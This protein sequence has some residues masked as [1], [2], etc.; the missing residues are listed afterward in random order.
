M[1]SLQKS[2]KTVRSSTTDSLSTTDHH[3]F[4]SFLTS[5]PMKKL[6]LTSDM[7]RKVALTENHL[8]I[9]ISTIKQ[10][11]HLFI[12]QG[13]INFI[14]MSNVICLHDTEKNRKKKRTR[15][16]IQSLHSSLS[17]FVEAFLLSQSKNV[18]CRWW[19]WCFIV[20]I[21]IAR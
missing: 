2:H 18:L 17:L 7:P 1:K 11:K 12:L 10:Q 19:S 20:T 8:E 21:I 16:N 15:S 3:E 13:N 9:L 6:L 4:R 14:S 5:N